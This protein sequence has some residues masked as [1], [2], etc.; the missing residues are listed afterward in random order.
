MKITIRCSPKEEY[1]VHEL[2]GRAYRA[3]KDRYDKEGYM[4]ASGYELDG[5]TF[6]EMIII[7]NLK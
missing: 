4:P 5:V 6:E 3:H 2:V 1:K 7:N